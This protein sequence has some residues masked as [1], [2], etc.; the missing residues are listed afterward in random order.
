MGYLGNV[1]VFLA[2]G[3]EEIEGLTVVDLLRRAGINVTTLSINTDNENDEEKR[4]VKGARGITVIADGYV[5]D[6]TAD[7]VTKEADIVVLP[8]GMPGTL[9]LKADT[10][11]RNSVTNMF[12]TDGK[13]VAAICAAPTVLADLGI[14]EGK[15]ATCYPGM[16]DQLTGAI[17]KNDGTSVVVDGNVITSRGLGTAI[18]FSLKMIEIL[19]DKDT[20]DKIA[21]SVVYAK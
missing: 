17:T 19:K 14:L 9:N 4:V 7:T 3:F 2:D 8:G 12:N 13:F 16:E 20:A 21:S 18:D 5:T 11:V 1:V 6:K 10:R 15:N